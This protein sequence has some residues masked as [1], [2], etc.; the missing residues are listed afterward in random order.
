M[1]K[2]TKCI[3]VCISFNLSKSVKLIKSFLHIALIWSFIVRFA[4]KIITRFLTF[5]TAF[6]TVLPTVSELWSSFV[7]L[8]IRIM[9]TDLKLY[10]TFY[11]YPCFTLTLYQ[12]T[13]YENHGTWSQ[14]VLS[15]LSGSNPVLLLNSYQDH[16]D[17]PNLF[18]TFTKH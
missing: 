12:L 17:V 7:S 14:L 11:H 5:S 16:G 15:I 2:C 10:F 6:T 3:I 13:G 18:Y 4:L 8:Y 9:G 1:H